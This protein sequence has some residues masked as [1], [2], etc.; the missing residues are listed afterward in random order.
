MLQN[1][2][3]SF[4]T[5][6]I[7]GIFCPP[8]SAKVENGMGISQNS[9]LDAPR[10]AFFDCGNDFGGSCERIDELSCSG[11]LILLGW[12]IG[13]EQQAVEWNLSCVFTPAFGRKHAFIDGKEAAC[14]ARTDELIRGTAKP[15]ED[16]GGGV[17][18]V[19]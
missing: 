10:I 8:G 3:T 9:R 4:A 5:V 14:V 15:V 17:G 11:F 7:F 1:N 16:D 19:L 6:L 2:V 13:F 18:I 12:R